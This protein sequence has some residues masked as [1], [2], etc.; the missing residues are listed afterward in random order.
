[1]EHPVGFDF[2]LAC[3][4]RVHRPR[5]FWPRSPEALRA[6][7]DGFR[8]PGCRVAVTEIGLGLLVD[9]DG[10]L[11]VDRHR[12]LDEEPSMRGLLS[13]DGLRFEPTHECHEC[14]RQFWFVRSRWAGWRRK[15]AWWV[16]RCGLTF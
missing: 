6:R 1:V 9:E 16:S 10:V 13:D 15:L 8:C 7:I 12:V 3:G 14:G 4:E 11:K 2:C 5:R